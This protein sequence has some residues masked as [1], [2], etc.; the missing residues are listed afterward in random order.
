[1]RFYK[2]FL[3]LSLGG[4]GWGEWR[5]AGGQAKGTGSS[6]DGSRNPRAIVGRCHGP[7]N[8][9]KRGPPARIRRKA[10]ALITK[11]C[12]HDHDHLRVN[13]SLGGTRKH[14]ERNLLYLS[15]VL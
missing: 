4:G 11:Q 5:R 9:I 7:V 10:C 1:M 6:G 15:H 2:F 3:L 13:C 12:H 14:I 8:Q